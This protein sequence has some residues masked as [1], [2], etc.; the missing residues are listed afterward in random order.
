MTRLNQKAE[1]EVCEA[2]NPAA[3]EPL[4]VPAIVPPPTTD[5]PHFSPSTYKAAEIV[6]LALKFKSLHDMRKKK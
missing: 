4:L 5:T 3:P 2:E 6:D 1:E